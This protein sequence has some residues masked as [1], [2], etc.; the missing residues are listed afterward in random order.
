MIVIAKSTFGAAR[1]FVLVVLLVAVAASG[2]HAQSTAGAYFLPGDAKLGMQT[3]FEKGCARCHSV[4]GEGGRTAPDLARAPGGNLG[5]SIGLGLLRKMIDVHV[6]PEG[7]ALC[8]N[9]ENRFA[10]LHIGG[11]Y[12]EHPVET[13]RAKQGGV[14]HVSAICSTQHGYILQ[15]LQTVEL[16][17]EETMDLALAAQ[18]WAR[19]QGRKPARKRR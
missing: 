15:F 1:D 14:D 2:A 13:P 11:R 19:K 16:G 17:D 7:H 8:V 9:A 6:V 18:R 3:F 5:A 4:L 12:V 10:R